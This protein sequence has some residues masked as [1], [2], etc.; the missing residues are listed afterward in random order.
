MRET[1][2]CEELDCYQLSKKESHVE[3]E[4]FGDWCI[5]SIL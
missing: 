3:E 2:H 1:V 4:S 5:P